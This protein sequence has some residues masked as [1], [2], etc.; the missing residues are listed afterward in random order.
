M[1]GHVLVANIRRHKERERNKD[2]AAVADKVLER[3]LYRRD[4]ETLYAR[5]QDAGTGDDTSQFVLGPLPDAI[6]V[7]PNADDAANF[8]CHCAASPHERRAQVGQ[9]VLALAVGVA[10]QASPDVGALTDRHIKATRSDISER[11]L[12]A[13]HLQRDRIL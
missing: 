9:C 13:D 6:H 8:L 3:R 4:I 7:D 11:M 1:A 2:H 12:L 10:W 5:E